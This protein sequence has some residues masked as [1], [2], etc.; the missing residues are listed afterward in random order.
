MY[1]LERMTT[2]GSKL[3]GDAA[4]SLIPGNPARL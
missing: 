4:G 3:G 2:A 1:A